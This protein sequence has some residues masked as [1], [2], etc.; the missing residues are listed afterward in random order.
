[1][2]RHFEVIGMLAPPAPRKGPSRP[3]PHSDLSR[4][5]GLC[6]IIPGWHLRTVLAH[7]E[8]LHGTVQRNASLLHLIPV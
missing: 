3:Y 2:T 8:R 5:R 4:P 6:N 1:M 7:G